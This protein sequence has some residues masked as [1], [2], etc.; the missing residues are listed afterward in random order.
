MYSVSAGTPRANI[1][2]GVFAT[3]NSRRVALLT[4]TSVA[5]ADSS[6]AA[7]NSKTLV[8]SSSVF[9]SGLAA[10]SVAKKGSISESFIA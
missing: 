3:A 7:S 2:A 1:F 5:C 9:G 8:Y 10:F 6:T 4:P